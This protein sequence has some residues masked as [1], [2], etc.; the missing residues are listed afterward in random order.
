MHH[1]N[2]ININN[3]QIM[4]PNISYIVHM[5]LNNTIHTLL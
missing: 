1:N 4:V 5:W 2:I 3:I